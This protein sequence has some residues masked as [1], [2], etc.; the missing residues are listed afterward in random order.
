[1]RVKLLVQLNLWLG[2]L[3]HSGTQPDYITCS[4]NRDCFCVVSGAG[5]AG[6]GGSEAAGARSVDG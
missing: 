3:H 2:L 4:S 1:M 5:G 6:G